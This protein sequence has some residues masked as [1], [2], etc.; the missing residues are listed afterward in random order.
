MSRLP[1]RQRIIART[2]HERGGY[3]ETDEGYIESGSAQR[4]AA[5]ADAHV[6]VVGAGPAGIASMAALRRDGV[7]VTCVD[8][9]REVA[10]RWA[11][12]SVI[13][14]S[15][16]YDSLKLNNSSGRMRYQHASLAK[17]RPYS[18]QSYDSFRRYLLETVQD[19]DLASRIQLNT[20]V[21]RLVRDVDQRFPWIVECEDGRSL[22]A[23]HVI[24][25]TGMNARPVVPDGLCSS[26]AQ[27]HS[28]TYVNPLPYA[29]KEVLVVGSGNTG[30][31]IACDLADHA[32]KVDLACSPT[33]RVVPRS[34]CGFPLDRLDGPI[35]SRFP[36][37][38]RNA[39]HE[40][41]LAGVSRRARAAGLSTDWRP[42]LSEG[43]T[44]SSQLLDFVEDGLITVR[45]RVARLE[46]TVAS[47]ADG[48]DGTYDE[49]ILATGYAPSFP[50][51]P[52]SS[53]VD[54]G[55]NRCFRKIL[56]REAALDGVF[57]VGAVLPFGPLL[58]TVEAQAEWVTA[59]V[60][61]AT[62]PRRLPPDD[63]DRFGAEGAGSV[64]V[65]PFPYVRRLRAD[66]RLMKRYDTTR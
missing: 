61:T 15:P 39:W 22:H 49:I 30:V 52:G 6:V 33:L 51:M 38:V 16:V 59:L 17:R 18:Y 55:T 8:Q 9:S 21:L 43:W 42:L 1:R 31:D 40:M 58:Q 3:Q 41:V 65:D 45:P 2:H 47:F 14:S 4:S 20:G 48:R 64:L 44:I 27:T 34:F 36:H 7:E 63:P 50:G 24:L 5:R 56:P 29:G 25:A 11:S 10:G 28:S 23:S 53:P 13:P 66:A 35:S 62:D 46:G 32:K 60:T 19:L 37:R 12:K 26:E 54:R 57:F